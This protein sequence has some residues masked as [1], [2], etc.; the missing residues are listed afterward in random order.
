ME[1]RLCTGWKCGCVCFHEFHHILGSITISLYLG[2]RFV[3]PQP[4]EKTAGRADLRK[5]IFFLPV[6]SFG[7]QIEQAA[8][9]IF[10]PG[11]VSQN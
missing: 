3:P 9:T 5:S 10:L 7:Y 1:L 8:G 11:K 6:R 2:I 4:I